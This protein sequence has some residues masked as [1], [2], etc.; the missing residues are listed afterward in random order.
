MSKEHFSDRIRGHEVPADAGAWENME[1]LLDGK[2]AAPGAKNSG[3]KYLGLILL[4]IVFTAAG[5]YG[6][7][8]LSGT[9][10]ED[11]KQE[12]VQSNSAEADEV[13]LHSG[14]EDGATEQ[15]LTN[16]ENSNERQKSEL[17]AGN[18]N[19]RAEQRANMVNSWNSTE[20]RSEA[21][22]P[23]ASQQEATG[24]SNSSESGQMIRNAEKEGYPSA[25]LKNKAETQAIDEGDRDMKS[26]VNEQLR[27]NSSDRVDTKDHPAE[28]L[29][30]ESE[31]VKSITGGKNQV[32]SVDETMV[33]PIAEKDVDQTVSGE[34]GIAEDDTGDAIEKKKEVKSIDP[35]ENS[36]IGGDLPSGFTTVRMDGYE[37]RPAGVPEPEVSAPGTTFSIARVSF[38][39]GYTDSANKF[40]FLMNRGFTGGRFIVGVSYLLSERL[41]L[42]TEY[43]NTTLRLTSQ[44]SN[45]QK[46]EKMNFIGQHVHLKYRLA[47]NDFWELRVY[48]GGGYGKYVYDSFVNPQ[49]GPLAPPIEIV[50][51][52]SNL[53]SMDFGLAGL[54]TWSNIWVETR[55]GFMYNQAFEGGGLIF[56]YGATVYYNPWKNRD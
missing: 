38:F 50:N 22:Q 51:D 31:S 55:F 4:L 16:S 26:E 43:G 7:G 49:T 18:A 1:A 52:A 27:V 10:G 33:N 47:E 24:L 19:T 21:Q 12:I 30:G 44:V 39:G 40:G 20:D 53:L 36:G 41:R 8:V 2:A 25:G 32:Q 17:G 23:S 29:D 6:S 3:R 28:D 46:N 34:S 11:S 42:E 56:S 5:L 45:G 13:K 35:S 15:G 54:C 37:N 9:Q 48:G 14:P